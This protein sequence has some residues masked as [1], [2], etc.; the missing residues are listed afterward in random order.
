MVKDEA[1]ADAP[2]VRIMYIQLIYQICGP[3]VLHIHTSRGHS[4][5]ARSTISGCCR[6]LGAE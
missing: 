6:S 5:I 4:T 1:I 2:W 3:E